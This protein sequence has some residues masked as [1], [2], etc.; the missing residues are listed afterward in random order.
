MELKVSRLKAKSIQCVEIAL[1]SKTGVPEA[2]FSGEGV[3]EA[4]RT[5]LNTCSK[6]GTTRDEILEPFEE[7]SRMFVEEIIDQLI[8]R[9]ILIGEDSLESAA[10]RK[11]AETK[12]FNS[13]SDG[14]TPD[15]AEGLNQKHIIVLGVNSISH[16]IIEVLRSSLFARV[17][18]VDFPLLRNSQLF[19]NTD[20]LPRE[21]WDNY[22]HLLIDKNELEDLRGPNALACL[23]ATSD[24]GGIQ[25]IREWNN[26][27]VKRQI[28][29]LPVFLHDQIGYVGP[30]VIPGEAPC[31]ECLQARQ[32]SHLPNPH[33]LKSPEQ[34]PFEGRGAGELHP[35][36]TSIL[37]NLAALELTRFYTNGLPGSFIGKTLEVDLLQGL[38]TT[39]RILKIPRCLVCSPL[40]FRP[41][42]SIEKRNPTPT[43]RGEH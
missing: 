6:T 5:I 13:K 24:R 16:Q 26:F 41:S 14:S 3:A 19:D 28:P 36:L 20:N 17:S 23:V 29:F 21:G 15:L 9:G 8:S 35:F 4:V 34:M 12:N 10:H 7:S 22:S 1:L 33:S 18:I 43:N 27:C 25:V 37:G 39:R 40:N 2:Q 30:L 42:I 31:F 11:Q 38:M 32:N